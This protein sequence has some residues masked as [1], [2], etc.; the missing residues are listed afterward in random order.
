MPIRADVI[1]RVALV[2][3]LERDPGDWPVKPD[4]DTGAPQEPAHQDRRNV[5]L[6]DDSSAAR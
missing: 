3:L 1:E 6:E 5:V 4:R 2:A